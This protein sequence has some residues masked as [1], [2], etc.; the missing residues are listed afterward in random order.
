MRWPSV[1]NASSS[2][3]NLSKADSEP[4]HARR[5]NRQPAFLTSAA[6]LADPLLNSTKMSCLGANVGGPLARGGVIGAA[7][8]VGALST[9]E[10][11]NSSEGRAGFQAVRPRLPLRWPELVPAER[12]FG[13]WLYSLPLPLLLPW[14][15]LLPWPLLPFWQCCAGWPV[16]PQM[17]H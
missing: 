16:E 2:L 13:F 6:R 17:A 10:G 5:I 11:P 8:V 3:Y 7:N 1:R 15:L 4:R 14:S 9:S 12:S